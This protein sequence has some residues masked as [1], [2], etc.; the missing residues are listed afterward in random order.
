MCGWRGGP[1]RWGRGGA[2]LGGPVL[3]DGFGLFQDGEGGL[4]L[5]VGG[6]AVFGEDA[7]DQAADEAT[8]QRLRRNAVPSC[9]QPC[10]VRKHDRG[11]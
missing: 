11:D 4:G 5:F 10:G 9:K 3:G 1:R 8:I 7:A 6:V 2:G